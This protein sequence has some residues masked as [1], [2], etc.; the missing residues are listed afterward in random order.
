V[1]PPTGGIPTALLDGCIGAHARLDTALGSLTDAQARQ[2]SLLPGWSVG[3][4]LTHIARNADSVVRRL[5]A[6]ARGEIV[7]QYEGGAEG[8]AGEI[9]AG[10]H[11]RADELRADVASS[12]ARCDEVCA[13][14]A[15][16]V[17]ERPTIGLDGVERPA[18]FM[19]FSRW[20]EVEVHHVDLGLGY[21]PGNWP[22]D[23]VEMWLP[24]MLDG[25]RARSD[26]ADLLAWTIG[27]GP[28]PDLRP[29]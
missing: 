9:E 27:R 26:D 5:E 25:L 23:L 2:P 11:R 15:V 8:R 18:S 13:R 3:H 12:S 20:R 14:T 29:W 7:S 17:W 1:T 16:E 24:S 28:A 21:L 4:V 22:A 19:A 10:A 6:A